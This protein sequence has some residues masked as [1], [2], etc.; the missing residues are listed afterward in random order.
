MFCFCYFFLHGFFF[1]FLLNLLGSLLPVDD[2]QLVFNQL[3]VLSNA[4]DFHKDK[5]DLICA[6]KSGRN[7][8]L[9]IARI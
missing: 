7:V 4:V 3:L 1:L 5:E 9:K 2:D 8:I 6:V